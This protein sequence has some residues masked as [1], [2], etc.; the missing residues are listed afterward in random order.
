MAVKQ[1]DSIVRL[2]KVEGQVRGIKKLILNEAEL[3]SI[4]IQISAAK[5]ALS[6]VGRLLLEGYAEEINV[7]S[8][9]ESLGELIRIIEKTLK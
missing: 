7:G 5:S 3:Y 8:D 6:S 4:L 2:S 1:K 9:Q